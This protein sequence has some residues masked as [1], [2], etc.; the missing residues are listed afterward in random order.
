M[1]IIAQ[2]HES[3]RRAIT[4]IFC[5]FL[6]SVSTVAEA[7]S[8]QSGTLNRSPIR[9]YP[10]VPSSVF[11]PSSGK[12]VL[13]KL[14]G[15]SESPQRELTSTQAGRALLNSAN[16][17]AAQVNGACQI[18]LEAKLPMTFESGHYTVPVEI[19]GRL[20]PMTIDSGSEGTTLEPDVADAWHLA[21]DRVRASEATGSGG[22]LGS[23]YSRIVP[24]LKLGSSE[25]IN[26]RVGS[27]T[28]GSSVPASHS[29]R[30]VGIL[31][32][33]VLSRY[34]MEF[35]FPGHAL[36]LYTVSNCLGHFAPWPGEYQGYSA[37]KT[38]SNRFILNVA[39]DGHRMRAL[40]ATGAEISLV[41]TSAARLAGV[42]SVALARD[43]QSSGVGVGGARFTTYRHNFSMT[44]GMATYPDAPLLVANQSFR[45]SDML[46]GMDFM[47]NRR[48]WLSYSTGW[49][50]MQAPDGKDDS[51][52]ESKGEKASFKRSFHVPRGGGA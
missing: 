7:Q 52:P 43:L 6:L 48:V 22:S 33:N 10:L 35:D 2:L 15:A 26:L 36:S 40:V 28:G 34:D 44:I 23:Q 17:D 12:L 11:A 24:S 50:F 14:P 30:P 51:Q 16:N 46:L 5:T 3:K 37:E 41:T 9:V 31:G 29:S 25:W 8:V 45:D 18:K 47:K 32:A 38:R 49:V 42:D 1:R 20:Y 27:L 19:G 13:P 39:L 21:E 4:A